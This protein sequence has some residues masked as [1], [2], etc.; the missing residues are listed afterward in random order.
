VTPEPAP[1]ESSALPLLAF[2]GLIV[3]LA[4]AAVALLLMNPFRLSPSSRSGGDPQRFGLSP[5]CLPDNQHCTLSV[6]NDPSSTHSV[7]VRVL[8]TTPAGATITPRFIS[9]PPGVSQSIAITF[10]TPECQGQITFSASYDSHP[11]PGVPLTLPFQCATP[12]A[13][14]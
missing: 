14:P 9:V 2:A 7:T 5:S 10:P 6:A 11:Q 3:L 13:K 1:P 12:T 4:L 8:T